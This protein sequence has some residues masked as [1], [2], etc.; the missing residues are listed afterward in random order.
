MAGGPQKGR[1]CLPPKFKGLL[2]TSK[3]TGPLGSSNPKT[4]DFLFLMT[5][6]PLPFMKP[7]PMGVFMDSLFGLYLF[8][9]VREVGRDWE[10]E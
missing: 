4:R 7:V 3:G 6:T 8:H 9:P 10:P 1:T 2:G 5:I